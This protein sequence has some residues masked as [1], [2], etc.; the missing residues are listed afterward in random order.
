MLCGRIVRFSP[1]FLIQN[2]CETAIQIRE[3]SL[4]GNPDAGNA[5]N[6][7]E[8][9][10]E[11]NKTVDAGDAAEEEG[12]VTVQPGELVPFHWL[13]GGSSSTDTVQVRFEGHQGWSR[14]YCL[15]L[16][17]NATLKCRPGTNR[18]LPHEG[19]P[20]LFQGDVGF[21]SSYIVTFS[22]EPSFPYTIENGTFIHIHDLARSGSSWNA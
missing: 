16:L 6:R 19:A 20:R 13:K 11:S 14:P 7:V 12:M 10:S 15:S 1:K 3:T 4:T 5:V 8:D 2:Q 17:G 21:S 9:V 18:G 22:D